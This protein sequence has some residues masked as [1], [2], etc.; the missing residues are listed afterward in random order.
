MTD[1][2][3]QAL[4]DAMNQ[5]DGCNISA[6]LSVR[7][8]HIMPDGGYMGCTKDRYGAPK[9]I[10]DRCSHGVSWN[11]DCP[12]CKLVSAHEMVRHWGRAV[13]EARKV[14]AESEKEGVKT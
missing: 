9:V 2:A 14:I 6:P 10:N 3:Y 7:G 11:D 1:D 4:R 12:A 8:N 5:C 13:D